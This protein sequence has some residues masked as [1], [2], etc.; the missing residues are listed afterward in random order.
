[1]GLNWAAGLAGAASGLDQMA[2]TRMH[3]ADMVYKEVSQRNRERF[4][5]QEAQK[6][7]D[8]LSAEKQNQ[9]DWEQPF[10][11][12][13]LDINERATDLSG[14]LKI[15]SQESLDTQRGIENQLRLRQAE[16]TEERNATAAA[17][18]QQREARM[19]AADR[20]K[21]Y[22]EDMKRLQEDI[23]TLRTQLDSPM[24]AAMG[25]DRLA[26][27][28][29]EMAQLQIDEQELEFEFNRDMDIIKLPKEKQTAY[30]LANATLSGSDPEVVH[31]LS[32][33]YAK[34]TEAQRNQIPAEAERL[35]KEHSGLNEMQAVGAAID[36]L[37]GKRKIKAGKTDKDTTQV[38]QG[39]PTEAVSEE[40][41]NRP[42][43]PE[44]ETEFVIGG[45]RTM[46]EKRLADQQQAPAQEDDFIVAAR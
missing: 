46:R 21:Q 6:Q 18:D 16:A 28:E 20:Q 22:N 31:D 36:S 8:F 5:S 39:A 34:M 23:K 4:Q 24:S 37:Y 1:M 13:A 33:K 10:K 40:P 11:T 32:M 3:E 30:E 14:E 38:P 9:R 25:Q 2:G 45:S 15:L 42:V 7:R 27:M 41:V 26:K 44:P 43:M 12:R 19:T 35:R 29:A 17:I